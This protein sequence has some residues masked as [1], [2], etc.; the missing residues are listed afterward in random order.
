MD[1]GTGP[2]RALRLY[3]EDHSAA[4]AGGLALA[5]HLADRYGD[6]SGFGALHD[7]AREIEQDRDHLDA[8]R[9][10]LDAGGGEWKA[11]LAVVGERLRRVKYLDPRHDDDAL[12][13]LEELEQLIAGVEAKLRLWTALGAARVPTA[14]GLEPD[15]LADRARSQ[16]AT[17]DELHELAADSALDPGGPPDEP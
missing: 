15:R 2:T 16:L 8:I 7:V 14:D 17:L 6:D 10:R 11:S 12:S 1:N 3:L 9:Q 4:A 5:R 13:R